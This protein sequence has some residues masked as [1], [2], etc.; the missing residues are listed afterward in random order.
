[1]K[2]QRLIFLLLL[3]LLTI[4][5]VLTS[6]D[7]KKPK[8]KKGSKKERT[9]DDDENVSG[10]EE[11]EEE[12]LEESDE[13]STSEDED[14]S[15]EDSGEESDGK[16]PASKGDSQEVEVAAPLPPLDVDLENASFFSLPIIYMRLVLYVLPNLAYRMFVGRLVP[17]LLC[18]GIFV[19]Y[20]KFSTPSVQNHSFQNEEQPD[21]GNLEWKK[22]AMI[23]VGMEVTAF[24][25]YWSGE[26]YSEIT[27]R[28]FPSM[29][30][31]NGSIT[32]ENTLF[33]ID[34]ISF[35]YSS[36]MYALSENLK[37]FCSLTVII[38]LLSGV[39][40]SGFPGIRHLMWIGYIAMF[41][42]C[43]YLV[44][45][46]PDKRLLTVCMI[47]SV[48]LLIASF[49]NDGASHFQYPP[50]LSAPYKKYDTPALA[51]TLA[52]IG[53]GSAA[54]TLFINALIVF[55]VPAIL[56]VGLM[57][58]LSCI[59][60]KF[61]QAFYLNLYGTYGCTIFGKFIL[62]DLWKMILRRN[63]P[64]L[65]HSNG[66]FLPRTGILGIRAE[67]FNLLAAIL[68]G[69]WLLKINSSIRKGIITFMKYISFDLL[70]YYAFPIFSQLL[71]L[72][73]GLLHPVCST[74]L[75][76]ALIGTL[77]YVDFN[78]NIDGVKFCY[79]VPISVCLLPSIY[80]FFRGEGMVSW[81][82]Q[83]RSKYGLVVTQYEI[84]EAV[85]EK[86][87]AK[88]AAA[89]KKKGRAAAKKRAAKA[90]KIEEAKKKRAAMAKKIEEEKKKAEK[91]VDKTQEQS[92]ASAPTTTEAQDVQGSNETQDGEGSHE[93]QDG[94]GS[95][96][97]STSS[98]D[99]PIDPKSL[100]G[101]NPDGTPSSSNNLIDGGKGTD[102]KAT[103]GVASLFTP[104]L[105]LV[106]ASAMVLL[107]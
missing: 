11:S 12:E 28:Y 72:F 57:F 80:V 103:S 62:N 76:L 48:L 31:K 9:K 105:V 56:V 73:L 16:K 106:A 82:T 41:A 98:G 55:I 50:S 44:L 83:F 52:E 1:M 51:V 19:G 79:T 26:F 4:S 45:M 102:E 43:G 47:P 104:T 86:R 7:K 61:S 20:K 34:L 53:Y 88:R 78:K 24:F 81:T 18:T 22:V 91:K 93:N 96:E 63:L 25:R 99:L 84:D 17:F 30:Y 64:F 6:G 39:F 27:R 65:L 8:S 32:F 94:Q 89:E 85:R 33:G 107:A 77:L 23:Y 59:G 60:L 69:E 36:L 38:S 90:K 54:L 29:T 46:D 74:I 101:M 42:G 49:I 75:I 67:F 5:F 40:L 2:Y 100:L 13:E 66:S 3:L 92:S 71:T 15:G 14:E 70:G 35:L 87:E 37:N 97:S 21:K 68:F 10:S 58:L 95:N